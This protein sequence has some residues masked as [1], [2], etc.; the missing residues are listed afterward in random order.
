M[1][2][3]IQVSLRVAGRDV[4]G[5]PFARSKSRDARTAP[6]DAKFIPAGAVFQSPGYPA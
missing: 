5:P 1:G 4:V 3:R 6:L 2:E